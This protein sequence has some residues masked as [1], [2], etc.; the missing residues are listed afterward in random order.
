MLLLEANENKIGV[1]T[2]TCFVENY[3]AATT[4]IANVYFIAVI[5]WCV[6]PELGV[7]TFVVVVINQQFAF[8]FV[9]SWDYD[10]GGIGKGKEA[11]QRS[12][13]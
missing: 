8:N 11:H 3:F 2:S 7:S 10:Y 6:E 5:A 9:A 12:R 4:Q 13:Y 1:A